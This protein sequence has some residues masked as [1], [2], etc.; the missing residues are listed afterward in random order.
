[1]ISMGKEKSEKKETKIG[2][3]EKTDSGYKYSTRIDFREDL[4]LQI[5][6]L[7]QEKKAKDEL[8]EYIIK[9]QTI[10]EQ[11]GQKEKNLLY[12][13]AVGKV[14]LFLD[15]SNFKNIK[16]YSVF[17]RL[18]DEVPDLLPGLDTKRIQDHLMMMYRIGRLDKKMLEKA[19]WEQWYEI[20]KFKDV[21]AKSNV[22]NKVLKVSGTSSGPDLR[23]KIQL[24]L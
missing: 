2:L 12:Y 13:G 1:M 23:N 16:P 5:S 15:E 10:T 19:T 8:Q 20:S 3:G 21:I 7:M 14:L 22:L 17:R 18:A 9:V 24:L 4:S 11:F 6:K